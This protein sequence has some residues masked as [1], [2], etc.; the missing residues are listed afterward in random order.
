ML[1]DDSVAGE[2]FC[3]DFE[4]AGM[5]GARLDLFKTR[6]GRQEMSDRIALA[7]A[8]MRDALNALGRGR[9]GQSQSQSRAWNLARA[10]TARIH[11]ASFTGPGPL[12]DLACSSMARF[13]DLISSRSRLNTLI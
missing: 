8:R 5:T 4:R 2:R 6:A 13:S 7:K 10:Q 9:E 12:M 11:F 3:K 1:S